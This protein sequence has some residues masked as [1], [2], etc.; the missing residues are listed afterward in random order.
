MTTVTST[1]REYP[2]RSIELQ[3]WEQLGAQP[4]PRLDGNAGNS[5]GIGDMTENRRNGRRQIAA[6]VYPLDGI[7]VLL[8]TQV[9][10][11]LT[12]KSD[13]GNL[14]A[15]G[16]RL[17]NG[18]EILGEEIIVSAGSSQLPFLHSLYRSSSLPKVEVVPI[19][20]KGV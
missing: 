12:S 2:L 8:N 1:D 6:A 7:T 17:A 4:I 13:N 16:V 5:S 9:A 19:H 11:V 10:K 3:S 15:N 18:T 14:T 20:V